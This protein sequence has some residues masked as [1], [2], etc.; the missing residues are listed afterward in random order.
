VSFRSRH[1]REDILRG[2]DYYIDYIGFYIIVL[3][4]VCSIFL[5]P[6]RSA[7]GLDDTAY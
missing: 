6:V 4:P 2:S 7:V 1:T 3:N 5:N